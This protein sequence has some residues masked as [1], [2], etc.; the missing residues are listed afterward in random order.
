MIQDMEKMIQAALGQIEGVLD[1]KSVVGQPITI[2]DYTIVPLISLGFGFGVGSGTGRSEEF[3]KGEGSGGASAGAGGMKPVAVV[4][5]GPQG[6]TAQP[7]KGTTAS[8][9]ESLAATAKRTPRREK[10]EKE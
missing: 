6:A 4:L 7:L 3:I 2:G 9:L 1:S 10:G 5:I 8:L